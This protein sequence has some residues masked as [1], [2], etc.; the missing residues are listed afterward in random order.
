MTRE[1]VAKLLEEKISSFKPGS[2]IKGRVLRA[3]SEEVLIDI[4]YKSEGAVPREEF[5]NDVDEELKGKEIN[6]I[7]ESLDPNKNG[8]IPLSKEKAD[9]LLYWENI[10]RG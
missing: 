9:I 2:L 4:E 8:F 1:E 6:V 5:K 3:N 7:V 10:G